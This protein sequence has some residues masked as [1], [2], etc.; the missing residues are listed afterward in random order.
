MKRRDS[1]TKQTYKNIPSTAH[2]QVKRI[3]FKHTQWQQWLDNNSNNGDPVK[4]GSGLNQQNIW[5][6]QEGVQGNNDAGQL[7]R[8]IM[9]NTNVTMKT[10][11]VKIPDFYGEPGKDTITA[12]KFMACIDKCQVTNK[13]N[14]I[15]MFSFSGWHSVVKRINGS[16]P[17]SAIFNLHLH[18]KPG[19][20]FTLYLK[21]SLLLFQ[22]INS[23]LTAWTSW[24]TG[25][26]RTR[27][28]SFHAWRNSFMSQK[29]I[30]LP[31]V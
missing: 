29:K 26:M 14:D 15:T 11:V 10:E 7:A 21:Q 31:I 30:M 22:M 12:L 9:A 23:S 16:A 18:K 20:A 2:A 8:Q 6:Q 24:H 1:Q 3:I 5:Q 4:A 13:W 28:C 25:P 17:S 27:G 19:L